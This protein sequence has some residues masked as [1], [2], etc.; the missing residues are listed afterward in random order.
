[1]EQHHLWFPHRRVPRCTKYAT[2]SRRAEHSLIM[3]SGGPRASLQMAVASGILLG[4]FE[5]VGVLINRLTSEGS[6]PQLP[7][8]RTPRSF[9]SSLTLT[10]RMSLLAPDAPPASMSTAIPAQASA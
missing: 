9:P 1:M 6:R 8:P 4:V 3:L 2:Y 7:M 5:G 10:D